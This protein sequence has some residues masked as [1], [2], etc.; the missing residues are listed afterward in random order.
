MKEYSVSLKERIRSIDKIIL[1]CVFGMSLLS[2]FTILGGYIAGGC[3]KFTYSRVF[4]Q[5]F[6][7]ILGA[8]LMFFL[9]YLDYD[10]II[11]KFDK[12]IFVFIIGFLIILVLFGK[13]D[14]G[15][16]NW[17]VIP[18]L[19]FNIQPS[20]FCKPLFVITFSRHISMLKKSINHPLSLLQ[21][22][23]HAGIVLGLLLLTKDLGT[24]L[25]YCAMII[26]MLFI[27]GL[28][29]WY[30]IGAGAAL[31]A[32]F[33]TIWNHLAI[34][35]QERIKCGFNP[36]LDP[37]KYGYQALKSKAAIASGGFF[38]KGFAGGSVYKTLPACQSDFL[39]A[40]LGEKFGILGALLYMLLMSI[41][42]IR[43]LYIA[44]KART[45]YASIICVGI[46]SMFLIQ[47]IENIGM[48]L[49]FLPVI[50]I[51]LPFFSYGG[52]SILSSFISIGIVLSIYTHKEKYYFDHSGT[53]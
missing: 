50:G 27:S 5:T 15:N 40:V 52:S 30:F 49:A 16:K 37:V 24:I 44:R 17:L 12:G 14:M 20:E 35:Q 22:A 23:I 46:A 13:G 25:V 53:L 48:C 19:P 51:T 41:L 2:I 1:I 45:N 34:Y 11:S 9:S 3:S 29:I 42:I 10:D 36:E 7:V 32:L 47:S 33:P 43:L 6:S 39:F 4:T 21:L 26:F 28:S 8:I 38:G 18:F 31:V